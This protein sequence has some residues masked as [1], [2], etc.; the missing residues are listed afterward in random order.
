MGLRFDP[1]GGGQFK[2]ALKQIIEAE[3]QPIKQLEGRKSR[4]EAKLKLFQ[5]FKGKFT[6]IEKSIADVSSF[7]KFRELKADLGDGASLATV[8]LDKEKALPG[9]Y[10]IEVAQLAARTSVIS[11]GFE[12]PDEPLLGLGFIV[13]DLGN[14]DTAEVFVDEKNGSLRGVANLINSDSSSPVRASVI[15]DAADTETPW[16]LILT[17]KKD[18]AENEVIFPEFYFMDGIEDFYLDGTQEARNALIF[19]DGFPIELTSNS[20]NEFLPGVNLHL[21]QAKPE[22]PFTL[23]IT[24]DHQRIAGK[25]KS[26]VEQLNGILSFINKQNQVNEAS[27]TR[28][29]FAGDTSLQTVEYRIRNLLHEGFG[30]GNPDSDEFRVV[31]LSQ[32][33]VEF[34]KTGTINFKEDKFSQAM[35][36][37]FESV[38]EAISGEFGFAFQLRELFRGYTQVGSGML[39]L[40]EQ[41]FRSRIKDI[42]RQIDAKSKILERRQQTLTEQFSRLQASLSQLQRQQQ[43]LGAALP[44]SGSGG[45]L[46]QQL[47]GG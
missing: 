3:S 35:E 9:S 21:K 46:V 7:S 14:G 39:A 45:N 27:D 38:A 10:Q 12:N 37:N 5:E 6:G 30:V 2:Q 16:R 18:G 36:K 11:N 28:T 32:I 15:R 13:M 23:T 26:L 4:E 29:T 20:T 8:T 19:M 47:L 1:M 41:G 17:A 22:Q 31:H 24:E 44:G 25:V 43:A 40:R 33:G 42:D 34:D